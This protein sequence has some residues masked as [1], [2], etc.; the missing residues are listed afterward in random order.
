MLKKI[1]TE[2]SGATS[3]K[4]GSHYLEGLD[5]RKLRLTINSGNIS[6]YV[7]SPDG[8]KLYF[9]AR[10]EKGYDLWSTNARTKETKLVAKLDGGPAGMDLSKDGKSI[11]VVSDGRIVKVDAD[12]GKVS[13]VTVNGEMVLTG[14]AERVIYFRSCMETGKEKIL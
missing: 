7:L 12:A 8:E 1:L 3:K 14:D 13:P 2:E 11:F 5:N 4:T 10:M 9:A 6:D